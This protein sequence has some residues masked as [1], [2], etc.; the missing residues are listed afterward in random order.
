MAGFVAMTGYPDCCEPAPG[1][2]VLR[3]RVV[4]R[5]ARTALAGTVEGGS[6][7]NGAALKVRV[8]TPPVDG[9][10]NAAVR[11]YLA[12]VL[13]LRARDVTLVA[14]ERSRTK[15]VAVAGLTPVEVAARLSA[16][17]PRS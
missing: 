2:T 6:G 10:A 17:A 15:R 5:A 4:P 16:A 13:G 9:Q 14:G 12:R 8:A 7:G 11:G 3:L 1:G